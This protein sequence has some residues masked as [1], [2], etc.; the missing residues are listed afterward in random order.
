M[1]S[2][3]SIQIENILISGS[4]AEHIRKR[5]KHCRNKK[6]NFYERFKYTK[7]MTICTFGWRALNVSSQILERCAK[8]YTNGTKS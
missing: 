2:I 8:T 7:A 6:I 5:R 3:K 1:A 4:Y